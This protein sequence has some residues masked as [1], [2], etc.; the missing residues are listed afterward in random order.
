MILAIQHIHLFLQRPI[1][2]N[3]LLDLIETQVQGRPLTL[4]HFVSRSLLVLKLVYLFS[5][6][7]QLS[8]QTAYLLFA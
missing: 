4:A 8:P 6:L 7:S 5:G 2:V 3:Q 1:L